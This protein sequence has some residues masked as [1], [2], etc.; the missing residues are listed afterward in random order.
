[1]TSLLRV[2][3]LSIA[4][5][6][7]RGGEV[8]AVRGID[9]TVGRGELVSL[10]GES[11]S[12]KSSCA[13][14]VLGLL[15]ASARVGGRIDL[16]GQDLTGLSPRAW[17]AVRGKR[18]GFVPQDPTAGLNPTRRIGDQI[19]DAVR[20]HDP[21]ARGDALRERVEELLERVRLPEPARRARQYPHELSGG[22]R[23]RVLIAAGLAHHPDLLVADE[24][25]SALDVTVQK[26]ILDHIDVLRAELGIAVL[27]ITH[28]LGV[29]A[30]RSDRIV[31]LEQG[32]IAESGAPGRLL[33]TPAS[34]YT[35][36][37]VAAVPRVDQGRLGGDPAP[38]TGEP[39]LEADGLSKAFASR[40]TRLQAVDD[41]SV[42]L[43]RGRTL[44]VVGESGSGKSTLARLLAR[45][46]PADSGRVRLDGEDVTALAGE[47]LRL[48]RRRVQVVYQNPYTSLDP[49]FTIART[50]AE[51]L[52][53]F[54]IGDK[55]SRRERGAELLGQVG[56]PDEF[57]DRLPAQLS[58]GQLQRVAIARALATS[59]DLVVLDEAVSALD[60]SVQ[61]QILELLVRLQTELGLTM[62]F[63]SHDLA[64]VRQVSDDV[65]VMDGGRVIESGPAGALFARPQHARTRALIA[66]VPGDAARRDGL[67][68][69]S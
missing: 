9:F 2:E 66:A 55:V 17:R 59:P 37:L 41:V 68:N 30:D 23:Q 14:A 51:P 69:A 48:L 42:R 3:G 28:D 43:H 58:G 54:D 39:L 20:L 40:G 53:A 52:R 26:T 29:A 67:V 34:D 65:V 46:L 45:L 5:R 63:I 18:I 6:G 25:T 38:A 21:Q 47:P 61:A 36:R 12:G 24:P 31:V 32:A 35:T 1:M 22:M 33:R 16:D 56:L 62:V 64:V 57:L 4:Y 19:G 15:P 8:E 13:R 44:G 60:V 7:R 10:V 49:R 50:L 11:G 27:L